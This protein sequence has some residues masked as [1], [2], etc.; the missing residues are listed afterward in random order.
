[1]VVA[2]IVTENGEWEL[3]GDDDNVIRVRFEYS[4]SSQA[5][6]RFC[7]EK[8][9]KDT[10]RIGVP[11]KWKQ[12]ITSWRHLQC[13]YVD[14]DGDAIID[15]EVYGMEN[16]RSEDMAIA[17]DALRRTSP[18]IADETLNPENADFL[19]KHKDLIRMPAPSVMTVSLLP[20]QEEGLH[21]LVQQEEHNPVGGGMLCDQMGMGKTMQTLAL[22]AERKSRGLKGPTLV[23]APSSAMLQWMDEAK[24]SMVEG[25][26]KVMVYHGDVRRSIT[27]W[28]MHQ[29]DIVLTSYPILEYEYRRC[30]NRIKVVCE[31]CNRKFLSRKLVSHNKYFCGPDSKRSAKLAMRDRSEGSHQSKATMEK[32]MV[33]LNIVKKH[34]LPTPGNIYRDLMK[35]ANRTPV[36]MYV[37]SKQA[38]EMQSLPQ[39]SSSHIPSEL[40][41]IDVEE[42]VEKVHESQNEP[43][44][45]DI[46]EEVEKIKTLNSCCWSALDGSV[47]ICKNGKKWFSNLADAAEEL[48]EFTG[49]KT[50]D[51]TLVLKTSL[52]WVCVSPEGFAHV[53]ISRG[54]TWIEWVQGCW[55]PSESNVQNLESHW[56]KKGK[57]IGKLIA[58]DFDEQVYVAVVFAYAPKCEDGPEVWR[59][60]HVDGDTEDLEIDEIQQAFELVNDFLNQQPRESLP[61][62]SIFVNEISKVDPK[63]NKLISKVESKEK[64]PKRKRVVEDSDFEDSQQDEDDDDE[65]ILNPILTNFLPIDWGP[66]SKEAKTLAHFIKCKYQKGKKPTKRKPIR[67]RKP[68]GK[69][70]TKDEKKLESSDD[71]SDSKSKNESDDDFE[72]I[73]DDEMESNRIDGK[74]FWY[75]KPGHVVDED[76][77]DLGT[78]I[79][80]S[81][82]W[83]RVVLD[84]AHK[85]K[86]RVNST[87]KSTLALQGS[88]CHRWCLTG[89]PL[90]NRVGELYS[91]VRFL[92]VDKYAYY[93]CNVKGCDCKTM[94]WEA[95][96]CDHCGHPPMRHYS[97][98]N[99]MIINPIKRTGYVGEGER[100]MR[101]LRDDLL[102]GYMLRRTKEERQNDIHLPPLNIEV[103]RLDFSEGERDF[104]ES[105]YMNTRS[106]FDTFVKKGT[107]LHNYA[108][109][110]QLLSRL[111][112]ASDHPYLVVHGGEASL[113]ACLSSK[114]TDVCGIC[115]FDIESLDECALSNCRHTFHKKC[116]SELLF[117][118]NDDEDDEESENKPRKK[119]KKKDKPVQPDCPVCL[120]PLGITSDLRGGTEANTTN[121][122]QSDENSDVCVVCMDAKRDA[123][124]VPC[125]HIYLCMGCAKN[126]NHK[127]CPM[128]RVSITKIQRV[129]PNAQTSMGPGAAAVVGR[130]NIVQRISASDFATSCKIEGVLD[131]VTKMMDEVRTDTELPN[132][133]IIFSQYNDMLDLLQ[134]RLQNRK[135][136]AVKLVGSLPMNE[137]RSV[138]SAFKADPSISV[139]L[140][141][142]K[143][144][145]EGL[146][147]QE[148]SHVLVLEPWW[149][150]AGKCF[151][152]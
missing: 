19:G 127:A 145:G 54:T 31:Y 91:L 80:H 10:L 7:S 141:S 75:A 110:F 21:W 90:Q 148:A 64:K 81:I 98:F 150:P 100:A 62:L 43:E 53:S 102:G 143:A 56:R 133:A 16:V 79:L 124:L 72:S 95:R 8:I 61:L 35:E 132:K 17:M 78:S 125:G 111:R 44:V 13:F 101:L 85:I 138:L 96:L 97:Y 46:K 24:S 29:Y 11:I 52:C 106:R 103:C 139:I 126:L 58:R 136:R 55:H 2:L 129:D 130:K 45:I 4:K 20:F 30:Q 113:E 49:T 60:E 73:P 26:L 32:A 112:R 94:H 77:I 105:V 23:V 51:G 50:K 117:N 89:T 92:R 33:S 122:A 118:Q 144:G 22:I 68:K 146:N 69:L 108:H 36:N 27:P 25:G 134:W 86:D 59:V 84:E 48:V 142:L 3:A 15:S 9:L 70:K 65:S 34:S 128:C 12:W 63:R 40:E 76:G 107:L 116:V 140:M 87:A 123:L 18:P 109:I 37:N 6:C 66:G 1:M 88:N 82:S 121:A 135:I 149:N 5:K 115:Q 137:R 28:D 38:L 114:R 104:Y 93:Y 47:F 99:K 151:Y 39:S 119:K 131:E 152:I 57:Y 147:L 41:M 120:Q 67:K 14:D 74:D 42:Q 83:T 71:E